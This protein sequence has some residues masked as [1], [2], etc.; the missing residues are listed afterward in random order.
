[1]RSPAVR[2]SPYRGVVLVIIGPWR[3]RGLGSRVSSVGAGGCWV[4]GPFFSFFRA[5]AGLLSGF[6]GCLQPV[7]RRRPALLEF[8]E[9]AAAQIPE[10][11][12]SS[13]VLSAPCPGCF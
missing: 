6:P 11:L 8:L 12:C 10:S 13:G 9:E 5:G 1:M 7:Q 3:W 2:I 4:P